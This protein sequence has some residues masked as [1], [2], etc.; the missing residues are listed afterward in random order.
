MRT[1]LQFLWPQKWILLLAL[2]MAMLNQ[3]AAYLDPLIT[4]KIVDKFVQHHDQLSRGDY[5]RGAGL[6]VGLAFLA[7]TIARL[8]NNYQD[9]FTNVLVQKIGAK[10]FA[11]GVK[12]SLALPY[13]EFEEQ[14]SGKTL[15]IL[16]K[17][18]K[19]I[20]N[21]VTLFI[22]VFF[23]AFVGLV[24]ILVY[25]IVV[26][27]K[28]TLIYA[29]SVP[30][31]IFVSIWL[32]R[33]VKS[34]Q[35]EIVS[36]TA[37]LM[38]SATE[39]LRNI[40]LVKSTGLTD[41]QTESLNNH[42]D[43]IL[44]M[45][46]D[47]MKAIRRM[48]FIQGTLVNIVR[49]AMMFVLLVL[50]Y[51]KSISAGQ[52]LAFLLYAVFLFNPLQELGNVIKAWREAQVSMVQFKEIIDKP[53]EE[54][55]QTPV[56]LD[57]IDR[58][59][60][61]EVCFNYS[62]N[63]GS[64]ENICLEVNS[65]ETIALVGP[66]G[67]G[68]STLVKLLAGLYAPTQGKVVFNSTEAKDLCVDDFRKKIGI[69][70]QETQ[71]FSGTIKANLE[72]IKPGC[73][74]EECLEVLNRA[75]CKSLLEK[76]DKDLQTY[77]GEGGLKVSGGEKQR[78]SIARALLRDP[79]I[80]IFDEATSAL[81]SLT[82]EDIIRTIFD[83]SEKSKFI[84]VMIAHRLST[85]SRADRIYVLEKGKI[86]ECGRH[87]ELLGKKGLYYQMWQQQTGQQQEAA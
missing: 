17:V 43:E 49:A 11:E 75:E 7:V 41:Q 12:H 62:S 76:A 86:V 72:F 74:D 3:G 19:D 22:S 14:S 31:I 71:L 81:D 78:L 1:L 35:E 34:M 9:Y 57:R 21:F 28:V 16:Q 37:A 58:V 53:V 85:I 38:G 50:V 27:Y 25:S 45:E 82:E 63:K 29:I 59:R 51:D 10:M 52:F 26:S 40:E 4:G 47:K 13:F 80:L 36:H 18:R 5:F 30:L 42:N 2:L 20:E 55:P 54:K 70:T 79:D 23:I 6:M 46:I 48:S 60:F 56:N 87:D 66:S 67:S 33:R 8:A 73:T 44:H 83:I 64:V 32:T 69:V 15:G 65:G 61:E 39:S 24:F 77:I 84:M 68:K